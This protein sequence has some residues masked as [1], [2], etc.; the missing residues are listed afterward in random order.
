M[1]HDSLALPVAVIGA[2]GRSGTALCRVLARDGTPFIPVVRDAARW[3]VTG[4]PGTPRIADLKD[5][6][7]LRLALEGAGCVVSCAHARHAPAILEAAPPEAR[8]VLMG[9]TRR[10]SRWA[11]DHGNGVRAGEA[12]LLASGRHGV[13]LHPT[14]IYGAEGEDNVQRL[15][16]LMRRLPLAPLPGGGRSLVQPIHQDDVTACLRAALA[17]DWEKPQALVIAGPAPLH[18]A[19]F[20]AAVCRAAGVRVP[21]VLPVPVAPLLLLSPLTRLVPRLPTVR[22]AELR[23]L[24]E[25]KAFGIGPMLT[26]LGVEPMPLETGLARTFGKN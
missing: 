7:A 9:S 14:M 21:P 18:Y 1:Q 12:A 5:A 16:A 17:R 19:D 13:I 15:A 10:Y 20:V 4:L 6:A 11:D 24:T 23:R 8:I 3:A 26:E 25:D 2:S 22:A